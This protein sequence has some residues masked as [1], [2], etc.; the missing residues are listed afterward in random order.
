[1]VTPIAGLT[2]VLRQ[3]SSA[4]T[5]RRTVRYSWAASPAG[6]TVSAYQVYVRRAPFGRPLPSAW[7]PLR[8]VAGTSVPVTFAGGETVVVAVKP[9]GPTGQASLL[10]APSRAVTYP[11][12]LSNRRATGGWSK[13]A[14][15]AFAYS[16]A[17][18]TTRRGAVISVARV[19][20]ATRFA[21]VATG[22]P[23]TGRVDVYVA[24]QRTWSANLTSCKAGP[25][26]VL[27]SGPRA[28]RTGPLVLKVRS[29]GRPVRLQA[30]AVLR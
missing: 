3:P 9:V 15:R 7:T 14:S 13:V 23:R 29:A 10:S 28:Q 2:A 5:L 26:C 27:V 16:P 20:K 22:G 17:L 25:Q 8:T 30:V 19:V 21:L 4:L 24:G 12:R 11:L 6:E 18:Q 1:V